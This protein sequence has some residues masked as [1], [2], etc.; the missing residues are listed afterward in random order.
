MAEMATQSG[1]PLDE[2][3]AQMKKAFSAMMGDSGRSFTYDS[4]GRRTKIVLH[5]GAMAEVT[6]TYSYNDHGDVIEER[7]ILTRNPKIPVGVVFHP[8]ESGNLVP[9][10]PPSEWSPQ[11]E[12][13]ESVVQYKYQYDNFGN[14]TKRTVTYSKEAEHTTRRELTYY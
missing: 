9:E 3:K 13:P 2:I 12:M 6:R 7:T 5:Q 4:Q 14:W 10:K 8:D 1:A 11:P